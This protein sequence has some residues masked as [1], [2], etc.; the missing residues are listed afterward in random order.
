M[1]GGKKKDPDE[2]RVT[3]KHKELRK[4]TFNKKRGTPK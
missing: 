1:Q 2:K 4:K 3:P